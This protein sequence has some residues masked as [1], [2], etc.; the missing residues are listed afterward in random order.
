MSLGPSV[1]F[2]LSMRYICKRNNH[3]QMNTSTLKTVATALLCTLL[4]GTVAARAATTD[5]DHTDFTIRVDKYYNAPVVLAYYF[6]KQMLVKDTVLTDAKGC[7]HFAPAE[8]YPEGIY[9]VYF[10]DK[11]YFDIILGDDQ[12]FELRCDTMPHMTERATASGSRILDEFLKYQKY[13]AERQQYYKQLDDEFKALDPKDEAGK[14][15]LRETF[16]QADATV[17]ANTEATIERNKDN[18]LGVFLRALTD[19]KIP[20][21]DIPEEGAARD[22]ILQIKRYYY[23]RAHYFDNFD[24]TD[25]RLLRTPFF[26]DKV[27]KYFT[28]TL[29]QIADTVAQEAIAFIEKTR[30]C[31]EMFRYFVSH[32]YNMTNNSKIMG[33]DAA[34][35]ALADRYYLSGEADW[36][37]E[38]FIEDLRT[39]VNNIRH[40]LIGQKAVDLKMISLTGEWFTLSEVDAPFTILV[41]WEPSCGHCKKEIPLLKKEI[42]DKYAQYGIKIYAVYCQTDKKEWED[43]ITEHQLEEW[44]NVYDPYRRTGFRDYYNIKSTPQIFILDK[45]KTI[46]AKKIGVDQIGGFLD[47]MLDLK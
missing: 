6:N 16:R 12:T 28:E 29:P 41:F 7:A 26:I 25:G 45:D 20:E 1:V 35:V 10:P 43:F 3:S 9:V 22:S 40:I 38:K 23:Y 39:N 27:D 33:M 18:F 5:D 42:W 13:L 15:R 8:K 30:P 47:H 17:K 21:F 34:L 36:V 4:T 46:I 19:I 32:L 44:M 2:L 24:L 37:E 14:E 11:S 31:Y